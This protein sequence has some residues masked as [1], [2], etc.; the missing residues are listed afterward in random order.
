MKASYEKEMKSLKRRKLSKQ[1]SCLDNQE[2]IL[3]LWKEL[4]HN[5]H[6]H[7]FARLPINDTIRLRCLNK[8]WNETI[9]ETS[10]FFTEICDE[11]H[12]TILSLVT[13]VTESI[14]VRT[15]DFKYNK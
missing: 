14:L 11:A 6:G 4:P 7:V 13:K 1:D 5:L 9:S 15:L 10:S 3:E 12:P 2:L 8:I